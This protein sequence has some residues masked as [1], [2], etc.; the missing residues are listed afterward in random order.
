MNSGPSLKKRVPRMSKYEDDGTWVWIC[1]ASEFRLVVAHVIGERKQYIADRLI[2]L[3]EKRLSSLPLF[4]SDGLRFYARA[5]LKSYGEKKMFSPTGKRG[6]PRKPKVLPSGDLMYAKIVK[7]REN[8][9]LKKV[10]KEIVFGKVTEAQLISTSLIE[11]M[12]LTLR[13]DNNRISRKTIGFSKKIEKLDAQMSLYFS[14]YNFCREHGSLKH[15][16]EDG[17]IEINCP[18]KEY[19]LINHN[20]SLRELLTYPYHITA[21]Y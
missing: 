16:N 7:Q 4:V 19:G 1:Y 21:T 14:N 6:R 2:G 10:A 5:L 17:V 9:R 20:W 13:Q 3:T 12:N 11:R 18:A 8:G 15:H